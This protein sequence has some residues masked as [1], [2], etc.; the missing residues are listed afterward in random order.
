MPR[1]R[2]D[3]AR[4]DAVDCPP[5]DE[6]PVLP[7]EVRDEIVRQVR[8]HEAVYRGLRPEDEEA[9]RKA[10]SRVLRVLRASL[11]Q[12]VAQECQRTG[13]PAPAHTCQYWRTRQG[14]CS[15]CG[16]VL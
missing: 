5:R 10:R 16:A 8:G 3:H 2:R 15:M 14:V 1:P 11:L 6:L 7:F 13:R 9:H 12:C 4:Y